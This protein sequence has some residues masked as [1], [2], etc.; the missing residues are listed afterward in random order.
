MH[1]IVAP[2]CDGNGGAGILAADYSAVD[3]SMIG[4]IVHDIGWQGKCPRVQG[5]YHT[6]KGGT[7][8]NNIVYRVAGCGIHLWHNPSH[9]NIS[10]N[11]SFNNGKCGIVV[12]AGD[13]PNY[14]RVSADY[15]IVV[16]NIVIG[17]PLGIYES[18]ATGLNNRYLNNIVYHNILKVETRVLPVGTLDLDPR[19]V[20]YQINGGGDYH[21][22]AGSPAINAGTSTAAPD[23]DIDGQARPQGSGFDIG[24]YEF[25]QA[26][27]SLEPQ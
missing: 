9:I 21:L 8:A 1:D 20:N 2:V 6:H 12:G 15:I 16:N 3:A 23:H 14:G 17:N 18:G 4:N 7:I 19:L 11:L 22:A 25:S 10:N 13:G 5:L 24:P 26:P 27:S